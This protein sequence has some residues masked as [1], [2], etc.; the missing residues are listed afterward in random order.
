[1]C[2][3]R[4]VGESC[5][6]CGWL[7][8]K[9]VCGHAE[10]SL[11]PGLG[12]W[13]AILRC[14]ETKTDTSF[15]FFFFLN[16]KVGITYTMLFPPSLPRKDYSAFQIFLCNLLLFIDS[17]VYFRSFFREKILACDDSWLSFYLFLFKSLRF[18]MPLQS[19]ST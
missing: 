2:P 6:E 9:A 4:S 1:M 5:G 19:C 7:Q 8:Q 12:R 10:E 11:N 15:F 3:Q 16:E 18:S 17:S 14:E 13:E